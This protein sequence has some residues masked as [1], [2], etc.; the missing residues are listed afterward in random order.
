MTWLHR[1][2]VQQFCDE[3]K[4]LIGI[5]ISLFQTGQLDRTY[6]GA[7]KYSPESLKLS[8]NLALKVLN[9]F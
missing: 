9:G 4:A 2:K 6:R 5:I 3:K 1:A 7:F 8:V